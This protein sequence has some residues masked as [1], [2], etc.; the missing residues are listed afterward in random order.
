MSL[1]TEPFSIPCDCY[2][3]VGTEYGYGPDNRRFV[4]NNLKRHTFGEACANCGRPK[5]EYRDLGTKGYYECWWCKDRAAGPYVA[6]VLDP[7][8]G[9]R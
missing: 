7:V 9:L 1:A 3:C 6:S 8:A 2:E 5:T 4:K